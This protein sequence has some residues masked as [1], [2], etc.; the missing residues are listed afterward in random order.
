MDPSRSRSQLERLETKSGL[1]HAQIQIWI[2]QK[3]EP[4]SP[5]YNMSF[6]FF[7]EGE[8][9]PDIFAQTWREV[10]GAS[11]ALRT[12]L[13]EVDGIAMRRLHPPEAFAAEM[14]D[15]SDRE[16][17]EAAF[18]EWC[19]AEG[20]R[21]M[22]L[23][24]VLATSTLA[25]LSEDRYGWYL[26]QHHLVTDAVAT[27]LLFDQVSETYAARIS[28]VGE[29]TIPSS[30]AP[31]Y[32]TVEALQSAFPSSAREDAKRHWEE[33]FGD[34]TRAIS[35]YGRPATSDTTGSRRFELQIDPERTR[36]LNAL[37][38]EPGFE[39]FTPE[40]SRFAIF[41][42]LLTSWI[43]R[44]SGRAEVGFD[45]PAKNRASREAKSSIGLF[46]EMFPFAVTCHP[47]DSFRDL[48]ERCLGEIQE[49][50]RYALPGT[51]APSGATVSNVVL[52]YF[53]GTFSLFAGHRT[54]ADWVHSGHGDSIHALR[55]QIHDFAES[56]SYLL[57]FDVNEEVFSE[58]LA[59]RAVDHFDRL[60]DAL[61]E[62]PDQRVSTVDVLSPEKRQEL[63]VDFNDTDRVPL[64]SATVLERFEAAV[65][66]T[67][68]RIALSQ[69][70]R[71]LAFA[72]V[73]RLT[74]SV[75][76]GLVE[77]GLDPGDRVA[78][79]TRRSID[80]VVAILATLR[81]GGAYVPVDPGYPSG[82]IAHIL[83][84]SGARFVLTH[85]GLE[86]ATDAT[87]ISLDELDTTVTP[88][89]QL[90][91][92][93]PE[94]GLG[95]LAYVLY[96]SGSTGL[97]K[98]VEIE[99]GGLI[100][101]LEWAERQYV[102]GDQLSFPLFTSLS[103]DLTVTSLYLPLISGGTLWVYEE[104]SGPVDSALMDVIG[105]NVVDFIKLTPSHL[106]LLR[107]MDLT[108]SRLQR[109]VVGG[110]DF[111]TDLAAA[112][113]AQLG[114]RPSGLEIE[115]YNE[116]GPTEAVVGCAI[117]RYNPAEDTA[118]SVP[119]G[120]PADHVELLVLN[121][122]GT[123]V[124]QGV[125]GELC[126]ARFGLARGYH[127][128]PELTATQFV[129][130]PFRKGERL[131]RTG[132][133][134]RFIDRGKLDYLGRID[135]Q[136][137]ISGFRIEPGEVEAALLAD[138][139]ID[140]ATV[141][142]R[143]RQTHAKPVGEI[144]HC[145]SCGIPSNFPRIVFDDD[146]V[147]SI[148]RSHEEIR[149]EAEDY[150]RPT[151]ELEEIF[152]RG[153]ARGRSEYDCISLLSGGKDSTYVLGKLVDMGFKPL[154]F[155]LD[156][157]YISEEAKANVRRVVEA[158]GVD[159]EFATTPAMNAIFKDSLTRFSN[160]CNGCF[161]TIYT[162]SVQRARELGIPIIVTG[163]SRGQ[164]FETRLTENLF[165]GGRFKP[166]EVDV[167]VLEARKAY[168]RVDD[169]VSQ[170]LDVEVFRDDSIFD[171]V[172]FVDFYRYVDASL[173]DLVEYLGSRVPWI[174]PSDTGRSTN[175]L[176]ND[177]GIYIHKKERGFHNYALPYSWDVRLGHKVREEALDELD[178]QI[179]VESVRKI[180]DEIGYDENRL[181]EGSDGGSD[182]AYLAA[183]YV[184][185]E[186]IGEAEL[187]RILSKKLP[188]HLVPRHYTHLH[189]IPLTPNGKVDTAALP[190]PEAAAASWA[191]YVAPE[192]PAEEAVAA[193]WSTVLDTERVGTSDT[194]FQ[195]GGT[196]LA[197]MEAMLQICNHFQLDLPLQT[198]FQFPT[199]K[200]LAQQVEAKL[201]EEISQL[202][203]AEAQ[204]LISGT[205]TD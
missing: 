116:Y 198:L 118:T 154:A 155:T 96:T 23:D 166:E 10:A 88:N 95:D 133:L 149:D 203:D 79:F 36:R 37:V 56:G 142:P 199:V 127:G 5:M 27:E 123:P 174:R 32:P 66:A 202:S 41:A 48:G 99:H 156:N 192:G 4:E 171:E 167:A 115:I 124:P 16:D 92:Q 119:I 135:H 58:E 43:H 134:A 158:L 65:A 6:A 189:E 24:G 195:L 85:G 160:V 69:G 77:R 25:R 72:E 81:A 17:P 188:E 153:K 75:A 186:P 68:D 172:E 169:A 33:K 113:D 22:A 30:G 76:L 106:S 49:L 2:G 125:P 165:Q 83:D 184:S 71:E 138:R 205:A 70:G 60:L 82:R 187:R 93:L 150:F 181:S 170:N 163:L 129:E 193:I 64:P 131:Y 140:G 107:Q 110:E 197:A 179:D 91:S 146:G 38:D 12:Y 47:E 73:E 145:S 7:I 8:I 35:L 200:D 136:V 1:S 183:Y 194:F 9:D 97:P 114:S 137:K 108:S 126:I 51:S 26:K 31:Y 15:L 39:S 152:R 182:R 176:I 21:T 151:A 74:R 18:S 94:L 201:I 55:L 191:Q 112:I 42:T 62:S 102:R 178:D 20:A 111:R 180:L 147:C 13:E 105:E 87:V 61:L 168:H 84:D 143:R 34:G 90:N 162:L 59:R 28:A 98:G 53:P 159:H 164:F 139:R 185:E 130:H 157:G 104:P 177:A 141:V 121:E 122:A 78:I 3:L 50:L 19:Q 117:H 132:D 80:A 109:M 44:A 52:N 173:A 204:Q 196:S 175:C 148:C 45:A 103:F 101:Y 144:E 67:P 63:L 89:D 57:Q 29:S 161:K 120:R 14:L 128:R 40:I 54:R 190:S 86:P 46:V 11:D 100:D